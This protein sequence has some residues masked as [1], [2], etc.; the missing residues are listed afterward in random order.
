VPLRD[1]HGNVLKWY[2]TLTDIEDRKRSEEER[3][4]FRQLQA[5]LAHENRVS[6]MGELAT[7]LSHELKQPIA[8]AI[9]TPR[10]PCG[11]LRVTSPMWKRRAKRQ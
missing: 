3:E 6:M 9:T 7:S 8:A 4:R 2:G 10:P 11:G 5:D 1:E